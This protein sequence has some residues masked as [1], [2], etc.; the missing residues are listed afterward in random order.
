M[1]KEML[2]EMASKL[3]EMADSLESYAGEDAQEED[4]EGGMSA[5]DSPSPM[6]KD[7]GEGGAKIKMAASAIKRAMNK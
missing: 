6:G 5:S 4:A 1:P 2:I 3:K 7:Y